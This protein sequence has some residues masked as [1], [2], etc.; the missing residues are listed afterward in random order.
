[1]SALLE[2]LQWR[3]ATKKMDPTKTVPQDKVERIL[4]AVRLT[5]SSSGLHPYEVFVVT[6]PALREQIKPH[7]WNQSQVTD[8]SHLLV[9][10]AWDNYT[11]ERINARFDLVNT[12]RGFRNEGWEAYRQQILATYPQRDA[13]TNYQHAAR[14]AYIGVGTALIA[15]AQEKVDS[16]PMEGFDPAK[17]DEILKLREKGLRS[18]VMLP[19]GYRADAGDWLVDLKKVRPA[20]EQFITELA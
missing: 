14:Q 4:E 13:E 12:V 20:R 18:V 3:Y 19:L 9:F 8:A 16:T 10:A 1:M 2:T 7:A 6:N 11:A 17:V 5:A 15:A